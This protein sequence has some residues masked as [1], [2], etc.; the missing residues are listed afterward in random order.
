MPTK[1]T[2]TTRPPTGLGIWLICTT[3][4]CAIALVMSLQIERP[5]EFGVP[6]APLHFLDDRT[7]LLSPEFVAAKDQYIEYLSRTMRIAQI[8]I[9]ILPKVPDGDIED[10]TIRAV[11]AWKVGDGKVDNGLV[12]FIFRDARMIRLE[13]GYGLESVITDGIARRLLVEQLAPAFDRGQFEAGIEDFLDGLNKL[14]ESSEASNQRAAPYAALVPFVMNVIH[15]SPRV[16]MQ[17]W[18]G[19]LEADTKERMGFSVFAVVL[20]AVL[21]RALLGLLAGIP[22]LL[23]LPWRIYSSQN[24]RQVRSAEVKDQF[25]LKNLVARPPRFLKDLFVELQLGYVVMAIYQLAG[26]VVGVGFLFVGS[27]ILIGGLGHFGGAGA[28]V[29]WHAP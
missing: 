1:K 8:N 13:V 18:H 7:G 15:A 12:L 17:V 3:V 5:A 6:A 10:F 2:A 22:A 20:G 9:V 23:M 21:I 14:L 28:S 26:I 19:F 29:G 16:G 24:L 27:S 25:R 11:T 4:A